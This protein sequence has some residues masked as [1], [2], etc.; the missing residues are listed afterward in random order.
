MT[1]QRDA[2]GRVLFDISVPLMVLA[3]ICPRPA[4]RVRVRQP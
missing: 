1:T 2:I 4:E 3:L